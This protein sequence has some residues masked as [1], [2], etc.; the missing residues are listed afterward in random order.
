MKQKV[1]K[2]HETHAVQ[3]E[4]GDTGRHRHIS[5]ATLLMASAGVFAVAGLGTGAIVF[6]KYKSTFDNPGATHKSM[7]TAETARVLAELGKVLKIEKGENPTVARIESP[8]QLK[9]ANK[10]FYSDVQKGDYLVVFS[11][12]AVIYRESTNQLINIAPIV[13]STKSDSSTQ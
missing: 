9:A 3:G 13:D 8:E 6:M 7:E 2:E 11:S 10:A 5:R 4:S 1:T 12:R